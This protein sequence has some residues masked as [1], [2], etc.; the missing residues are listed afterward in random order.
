M[1]WKLGERVETRIAYGEALLELGKHRQDVVV[2]DADLQRSNMTYAFGQAHP[3][4]FFDM[5]VAEAD[6]VCTAAGMAATG[7]TVFAT[8]FAMFVPGR[9]YDQIRLQL[10]YGQENVKIVGVSAGLT[11]GPDGATH[12]ALD[13]VALVRQLPGMTVLNPADAT[14]AYRAVVAAAEIAT[15]VYIRLGRYPTPVI[16]GE[17]YQF[18]IGAVPV[19]RRGDDIVICATGIMTAL[20][21]DTAEILADQGIETSVLNV[22]TIKPLNTEAI[23]DAALGKKLCVTMEEHW[24]SGGLGSAVAETLAEVRNTPPLLRIGVRDK[25][26]QSA[27]ADELLEH[28]GLT[29]V[30]MAESILNAMGE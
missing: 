19:M 30:H 20:A 8:S 13:D 3:E 9:A 28:Y 24:I 16:F 5:G 14:E 10:S 21:L 29:P 15:P 2:L 26:G 25:F 18:E 17:D 27:T 7:M 11:Q 4:R 23:L 1:K 12:Q 6:M 22:P